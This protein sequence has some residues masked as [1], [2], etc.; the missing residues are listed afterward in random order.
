MQESTYNVSQAKEIVL[1]KLKDL[2]VEDNSC[3]QFSVVE[4]KILSGQKNEIS[5]YAIVTNI[6]KYDGLAPTAKFVDVCSDANLCMAS[7]EG[8]GTM[9]KLRVH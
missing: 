4:R 7:C 1:Q 2:A 6:V 3:G 5:T 8:E 9:K